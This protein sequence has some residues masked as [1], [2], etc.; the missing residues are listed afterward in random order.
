VSTLSN[1]FETTANWIQGLE[2]ANLHS[3]AVDY[4]KTGEPAEM[5]KYLRPRRWPH[6]ME[7]K[8]KAKDQ[9]YN[10]GKILGQLYDQV[11]SVDFVPHYESPFDKRILG[12]YEKDNALLKKARIIK[13]KYDT[14]M[15]RIMAQHEITTEF[16][17]WT[18]FVLSKPRV[19][20]DYKLQEDMAI[21]SSALKDRFRKVCITEAGGKEF[22]K[23]GP[24][25][26]AMY[27]VTCEEL[28][29]A[30]HECHTTK[31]VGGREVPR[32][33]MEPKYMPLISFP[34]L[35]HSILGRIATGVEQASEFADIGLAM[36]NTRAG[37]PRPKIPALDEDD[38]EDFVETAEGITHRG[39]LLDLF[40]PDDVDSDGDPLDRGDEKIYT[41]ED[42]V[43]NLDELLADSF[44]EKVHGDSTRRAREAKT[45]EFEKTLELNGSINTA[46]EISKLTFGDAYGDPTIKAEEDMKD[47]KQET[48]KDDSLALAD[49]PVK[50]EE[51]VDSDVKEP[52]QIIKTELHKPAPQ[53]LDDTQ[54]IIVTRPSRSASVN[55]EDF[56]TYQANNDESSL[57]SRISSIYDLAEMA[58]SQKQSAK[59]DTFNNASSKVSGFRNDR[60][61]SPTAENANKARESIQTDLDSGSLSPEI[62]TPVSASADDDEDVDSNHEVE[63]DENSQRTIR[64]Q[65]ALSPMASPLFAP[66]TPPR[67]I[68]R[69]LLDPTHVQSA[70]NPMPFLFSATTPSM[71]IRRGFS[72]LGTPSPEKLNGD[73]IE[74]DGDSD[75]DLEEVVLEAI[76]ETPTERL[77]RVVR[78]GAE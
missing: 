26:A 25:V 12:A 68:P 21:V 55:L 41:L 17:I 20:S 33:K 6:F 5:P 70:V 9:I 56:F 16:E 67:N 78:V 74:L 53:C 38:Q 60:I 44:D 65:S 2:L 71:D 43:T 49:I 23:L 10:S 72:D 66:S 18:T 45:E 7:K 58:G 54:P 59:K 51:S 22:E 46:E 8:Y 36:L 3:K 30:L 47:I 48:C 19:G 34:W 63:E 37:K 40:R 61:K 4:V 31:M 39:E 75:D 29:I 14:A 50:R 76:D 69:G 35:F 27:R 73:E 77:E 13:T 62:F 11:E 42:S 64:A 1:I 52:V 15:R 32:R 57:E 24:F 28:V